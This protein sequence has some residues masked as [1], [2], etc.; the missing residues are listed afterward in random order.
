MYFVWY[1]VI[2]F[3]VSNDCLVPH[4]WDNSPT[5]FR[6]GAVTNEKYL[7][8]TSRVT[9]KS[10]FMAS[11][12]L[13]HLFHAPSK[14]QETQISIG[15][16]IAIMNKHRLYQ[17]RQSWNYEDFRFLVV[18]ST[19]K[20]NWKLSATCHTVIWS[21]QSLGISFSANGRPQLPWSHHWK[22]VHCRSTTH[23]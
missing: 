12:I 8:I 18:W 3:A 17:Q 7:R 5:V 2:C 23:V 11:Q 13:F 10:I 19:K 1:R 20:Y 22:G 9:K 16:K 14:V 15:Q 4:Q 21:R 6:S